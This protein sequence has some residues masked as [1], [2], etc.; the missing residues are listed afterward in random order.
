MRLDNLSLVH[1]QIYVSKKFGFTKYD[2]E[3]FDKLKAEGRLAHDGC[4]VQYRPDHGPLH[5]WKK[6]QIE[7]AMASQ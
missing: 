1:L 3:E 2:R 6:V 5:N 7:L 4:N